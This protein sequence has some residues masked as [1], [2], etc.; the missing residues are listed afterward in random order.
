MI[1]VFGLIVRLFSAER[2]EFTQLKKSNKIINNP[3]LYFFKN[4]YKIF[5]N[6]SSVVFVLSFVAQTFT[7]GSKAILEVMFDFD[8]SMAGILSII[9]IILSATTGVLSGYFCDKF[10]LVKI[11]RIYTLII[12][13]TIPFGAYLL[14]CDDHTHI[15]LGLTAICL[16]GDLFFGLYPIFL[17]KKIPVECRDTGVGF[18]IGIPAMICGGFGMTTLMKLFQ[19]HSFTGIYMFLSIVLIVAIIGV[20]LDFFDGF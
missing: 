8:S 17:Y 13:I 3:F 2:E 15:F 4:Y 6:C 9:I 18:S 1:G 14:S 7:I 5:F 11:R 20:I 19:Q 12:V 10:S 16:S